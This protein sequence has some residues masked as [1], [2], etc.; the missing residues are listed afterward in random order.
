MRRCIESLVIAGMLSGATSVWGADLPKGIAIEM[1]TEGPIFTSHGMTLYHLR[2]DLPGVSVCSD[3]PQ[4]RAK[5]PGGFEYPVP[6]LPAQQA[7]TQKWPPLRAEP[8]ATAIENWSIIKRDDGTSQWAY[9]GRPL[10]T[11]S[12]DK[13]PGETNGVPVGARQYVTAYAG[14]AVARAPM[15]LPAGVTVNKTAEGVALTTAKGD[16]LY[17]LNSMKP[18]RDTRGE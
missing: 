6:D 5:N 12:L 2:E 10:Y 15:D 8:D 16:P 17:T 1:S 18:T 7:C 13:Q 9:A 3:K 11:S 4:L 14:G